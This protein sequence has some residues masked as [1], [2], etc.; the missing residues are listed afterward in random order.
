MEHLAKFDTKHVFGDRRM[1]YNFSAG[2]CILPTAVYDKVKEEGDN[3]K[4]TGQNIM[5]L[6]HR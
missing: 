3:Y 4:G 2:P 5:E 1:N 6:S